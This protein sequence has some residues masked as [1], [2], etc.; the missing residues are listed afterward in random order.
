MKVNLEPS[1][2]HHVVDYL[3]FLVDVKVY[4]KFLVDVKVLSSFFFILP[5]H[6]SPFMNQHFLHHQLVLNS[7]P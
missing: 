2:V 6:Q 7:C 5:R 3:K 1:N 4:L